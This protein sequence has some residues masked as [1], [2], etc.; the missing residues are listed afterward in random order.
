MEEQSRPKR[1]VGGSSPSWGTSFG[2]GRRYPQRVVDVLLSITFACGLF[3]SGAHLV[4]RRFLA[5]VYD[6]VANLLSFTCASAASTLLGHVAPAALSAAAGLC[7]VWLGVRT[8]RALR[9]GHAVKGQVA[10]SD[11][12]AG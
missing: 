8:A 7:W 10:A 5:P 9:A 3:I 2:V 12:D 4:N 6:V 11:S 1:R